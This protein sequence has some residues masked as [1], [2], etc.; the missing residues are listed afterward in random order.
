[1]AARNRDRKRSRKHAAAQA[2][3]AT[4]RAPAVPWWVL[5]GPFGLALAVRLLFWR[6]TPDRAWAYSAAYKG[7]A[8]LWLEYA[9]SL[10][11][12][13]EFELGLPIHPPGAA[14]LVAL[15]WDGGAAGVGF[16]RFAWALQ[17]A[18]A[19]ALFALA[20]A[21]AFGQAV[22]AIAG[23]WM[24]AATGLVLLS[25]SVN[26]EAPYLLLVALS[27]LLLE[28]AGRSRG[29]LV[30]WSALQAAACLVRV[31]H[32]LFFLLLLASR[33][34]AARTAATRA[35]AAAPG[36]AGT[37][38]VP[39]WPLSR[40]A[41]SLGVF[42][43]ALAPWHV[44]AW[45]AIARVNREGP[46]GTAEQAAA[47]VERAF[48]GIRWEDP[49]RAETE[50]MPAFAR[51]TAAAF[52]AA[53]VAHRG[54]RVVR[55]EDLRVLED[56]FG[57]VPRPLSPRPFVSLYGPLNFA[58]ANNPAATGGFSRAPLDAPPPLRPRRADY[59]PAL[60]AGLPPP[61]LTLLYPPHLALVNEGYARGLA[62]IAA[63]PGAFARL[64][65][66]KLALSGAGATLGFGGRNLP[67][68]LSGPRRAVDLVTP[69]ASPLAIAWSTLVAAAAALGL[70]AGWRR[71]ALLPWLLF[72]VT[73]LVATLAF[74]GYARQGAQLIPVVA[75][76]VALGLVRW[77]PP[78]LKAARR[79]L[80]VLGTLAALVLGVELQRFASPPELALDG[81]T[82]TSVDPFA[83]DLHRDQTLTLR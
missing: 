6:A 8:L 55:A 15:L 11:G 38:S 23:L 22:G 65:A 19:V 39:G 57:Y 64:A 26:A 49:A 68:G 16:L 20:A 34:L 77:A 28:A 12:G 33:A 47:A 27:L 83:A 42:A 43:L 73:K 2:A 1:M 25:A 14:L 74:F 75:V 18:L 3:T 48:P 7:D 17:G 72:L 63:E 21:R 60:V 76:L 32:A 51:P 46:G 24:A 30:T 40:I 66:R 59:P 54:G 5:L 61:D 29:A 53:T 69:A 45:A 70:A 13:P 67:L 62:W 4:A 10:L 80:I 50:R 79:P 78:A 37:A 52:V 58:L 81:V 31:E 36:V 41:A 44:S 71:R 35:A 82:L 9:R 56:A